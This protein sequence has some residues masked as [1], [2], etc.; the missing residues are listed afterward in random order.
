MRDEDIKAAYGP[1]EHRRQWRVILVRQDGRRR[2]RSFESHAAA[3]AYL[4]RV[5]AKTETRTVSAAIDEYVKHLRER[6]LSTGTVATITFRLRGLLDAT[7][8]DRSLRSLTPA[9]ARDLFERR[10][11]AVSVDTQ[12]GE[13]D[14]A[15][16]FCAWA[17]EQGWMRS[18]PFAGIEPVGRRKR[19]KP[20]LRID[21]A[22]KFLH[23]A[24][25]DEH[26]SGI[27]AA[28][29]LTMGMRATEITGRVVRD[30]DDGARVLWIERAKTRAGDRHLEV[31]ELLRAPLAAIVA[32]RGGGERLFGDVDRHWFGYHVRRLCK[33]AKVPVICPHG[34][35]DT[36]A[37]ISVQAS[38][39][40]QVARALGH[41]NT[42]V[43]R[44]HY[45]EAGAEQ[46]GQ[47]RSTL[48]VLRGGGK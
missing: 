12:H 37:S 47:Q 8:R 9:V 45:L 28:I 40:D 16:A 30:V 10:R 20:T 25:A 18:D 46:I 33:V 34:L 24:L 1:Y 19:G 5:A 23:V 14:V 22:R 21:E 17:I 29:G 42:A 32:G 4:E 3:C 7:G 38:P 26:I 11:T 31:P 48:R 27:A 2:R 43:T 13:L 35:R 15:S 6:E 39:V 44:R 36:W 41:A